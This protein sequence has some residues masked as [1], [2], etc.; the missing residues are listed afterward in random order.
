[1]TQLRFGF[2]GWNPFQLRHALDVARA[3]PG[4]A[5]IVEA[6]G[7]HPEAFDD[8]LVAGAG[9]PVYFWPRE[10]MRELDGVFEVLV[11]QTVFT[12]I[13]HVK[14]SKIAMLQY[15]LA[16]EPHNYGSWRAFADLCLTYGPY[17]ARKIS[18]YAPVMAVGHPRFD[19]FFAEEFQ[20]KAR[21]RIRSTIDPGR[22]TVL[23]VPT[24]GDLSTQDDFIDAVLEL[25]RDHNVLLKLHHNTALL[26]RRRLA[27][28][29]EHHVRWFGANDDPIELLAVSDLVVSDYSGAIFDALYARKPVVLLQKN[30]EARFGSK[31]DAGSLEH[32][33]RDRIGPVI[34]DP[35]HL[36]GVVERIVAEPRCF[37]EENAALVREL[38]VDAE[39]SVGRTVAAL[40]RLASGDTEAPSTAHRELRERERQARLSP[41]ERT[42]DLG[43]RAAH[44]LRS[45]RRKVLRQEPHETTELELAVRARSHRAR[46]GFRTLSLDARPLVG[47]VAKHDLTR[48]ARRTGLETLRSASASLQGSLEAASWGERFPSP[49]LVLR[50]LAHAGQRHWEDAEHVFRELI[51]KSGGNP[52]LHALLARLLRIRKRRWQEIVEL[53]AAIAKRPDVAKWHFLLGDAC[54]VMER[55]DRAAAAYESATRLEPRRADWHYRLGYAL[56]KSGAPEA[57]AV[58]YAEASAFDTHAARFGVGAFHQRAG[59]YREAVDAYRER[60]HADATDAE[61][62]YRLGFSLDRC[63]LWEEAAASYERALSLPGAD[64]RWNERLGLVYDRLER[65]RDA[66]AAYERAARADEAQGDVLRYRAGYA[67]VRAGQF[68]AACETLSKLTPRNDSEARALRDAASLAR[69]GEHRRACAAFLDTRVLR[70]HHGVPEGRYHTSPAVR[71]TVDFIEYV[72]T[73]PIDETTILYESFHGRSISCNPLAIF[74]EAVGR[75][76][77]RGWTHVWVI[78]DAASIPE[79]VRACTNVVF[80]A[81]ESDLYLRHLATAKYLI[82]NTSFS[83]FYF[84]R[85]GQIYLNTWHGTP[86][87]TLGRDVKGSFLGWRNISRN[88]LQATHLLSANTHTSNVL[89]DRHAIAGIFRGQIVETG[90]PRIGLTQNLSQAER[91]ALRAR[92]G[93]AAGT[94]I[95]L[96]APTYRGTVDDARADHARIQEDV[97]ALRALG[98]HVLFRGHYFVEGRLAASKSGLSVVPP[99]VD[100]NQ[101][102]AIVDVLV[103]DYSSVAV[104]FLVTDKPI[105]FYV[106]DR[107]EY[108]RERGLYVSMEEMPGEKCASREALVSA[109]RRALQDGILDRDV[110]AAARQRFCPHED[111]RAGARVLDLLLHGEDGEDSA[112]TADDRV[113]LLFFAGTFFPHGITASFINLVRQ[114]DPDRYA[115]TVVVDPDQVQGSHGRLEQLARLPEHVQVIARIGAMAATLEERWVIEQLGVR[116]DV[117]SKPMWEAYERA[118]RREARRVFGDAAF[119]VVVHFDGYGLYWTSLIRCMNEGGRT[120]R[121]IYQH[122]DM[123]GEWTTK[124]PTLSGVFREY[125]HFDAVVSV[126]RSTRDVNVEKL[127]TPFGLESTPHVYCDN[128]IDSAEILRKTEAPVSDELARPFLEASGPKF[129]TMG[130]LSPEKD[131]AKLI[132]A[133]A[134][135]HASRPDARLLILGEG[136]LRSA[137]QAQ[138]TRLGLGD[139]VFLLGRRENPFPYLKRSDC[140]VFSSRYEGQGLVLLESLI[141]GIPIV[142]TDFPSAYDVLGTEHG[143]IVPNSEDGLVEGMTRFLRGEV[144]AKPFDAEA[145]RAAALNSFYATVVEGRCDE[146]AIVGAGH[147]RSGRGSAATP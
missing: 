110:H 133:F 65:W 16:K 49:Y 80:V 25:A 109:T 56:E 129:I 98:C 27:R 50:F 101:V 92:L 94:K 76:E 87:K 104:D 22:P 3:L 70:R 136:P 10:R 48:R 30:T 131:H 121:V 21:Q 147:L 4:S 144:V 2:V 126:S 17:S 14:R 59:R 34:D 60:A 124:Y 83:S 51:A 117:P 91:E 127:T 119:D 78:D 26:E 33:A 145:Y 53:E 134:R 57:A 130:R 79:V 82:N 74:L 11:C 88:F 9:V 122:N 62:L 85:E 81:R 139:A 28:L 55:W 115:V 47:R 141:V 64:A 118:Y 111:G 43:R 41:F 13:E 89:V 7:R 29:D 42:R 135:I 137:L 132:D 19:G 52:R 36:R 142:T 44:G 112:K 123:H 95:L 66:A 68:E 54:D 1:M 103:T 58:A 20:S 125:R 72:E 108:E 107:E 38:F 138:A 63:F 67:L 143:L 15:G 69:R 128:V 39:G 114:I 116:R 6:R 140:F 12:H 37:A 32:A 102:L 113:S 93:V 35:A 73:R 100:T 40:E 106:F 45:W 84:R 146:V 97:D 86:L 24:W 61:L 46:G 8:A 96:Y 18:P 120:R 90:Y 105:V 31:L 99:D 77:L 5:M 23:Y 75:P 71:A